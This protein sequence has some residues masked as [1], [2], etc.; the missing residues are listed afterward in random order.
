MPAGK[1]ILF[2]ELI[3][4]IPTPLVR[5]GIF[6]LTSLRIQALWWED[7]GRDLARKRCLINIRGRNE[8]TTI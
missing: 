1:N 3:W 5:K 7:Y 6:F 4:M 2:F 8:E